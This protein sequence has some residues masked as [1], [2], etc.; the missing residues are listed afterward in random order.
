MA[1]LNAQVALHLEA[2]PTYQRLPPNLRREWIT[3]STARAG[4]EGE[5]QQISLAYI[6]TNCTRL[7]ACCIQ[8]YKFTETGSAF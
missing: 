7:G 4:G 3:K 6:Y 8:S 1:T 5:N 2:T